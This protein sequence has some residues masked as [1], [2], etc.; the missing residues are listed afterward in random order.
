MGRTAS[1]YFLVCLLRKPNSRT[2][3]GCCLALSSKVTYAIRVTATIVSNYSFIFY[4]FNVFLQDFLSRHVM[5]LQWSGKGNHQY[6]II[7]NIGQVLTWTNKKC[8]DTTTC[9]LYMVNTRCIGLKSQNQRKLELPP[10]L[11]IVL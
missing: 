2:M 3:D 8:L 5:C 9:N 1:Q 11:A 10:L 4:L 7:Y 6:V